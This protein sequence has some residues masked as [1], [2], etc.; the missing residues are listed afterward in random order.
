[1]TTTAIEHDTALS[2]K[3]LARLKHRWHRAN[4][5]EIAIDWEQQVQDITVLL[6]AIEVLRNRNTELVMALGVYQALQ[7]P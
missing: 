4:I 6:Q 5:G 3:E 1:M 2:A 7:G